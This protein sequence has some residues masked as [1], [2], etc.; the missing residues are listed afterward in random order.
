MSLKNVFLIFVFVFLVVAI[1]L[2][3]VS[4]LA[5]HTSYQSR[6]SFQA[7]Y[8][9]EGRLETY[10]PILGDKETCQARQDLLLQIS[11]I[12]CQPAVVRSD[13]VAEQN[14]PVFCQID[15]LQI[16]PL[17][18]IDKIRSISFSERYPKD[19]IGAGFHPAK[20]ALRS[21]DKLLGSPLINNIGYVVVVLKR[22]PIE[23][24]LPDFVN[25]SLTARIDYEAGNAF[26]VGSAQYLLEPMG[27]EEWE[28]NKFR[29]SFWE[30]RYF[31]RLEKADPNSAIVSLYSGKRKIATT[32]VNK[33]ETSRTVWVPGA[34]CRAGVKVAY[35]GFQTTRASAVLAISGKGT[36]LLDVYEGSRFLNDKC[37]VNRINIFENNGTGSVVMACSDNQRLELRLVENL[38]GVAK[39]YDKFYLAERYDKTKEIDIFLDSNKKERSGLVLFN[40]KI[41]VPYLEGKEVGLIDDNIMQLN[42][43]YFDGAIKSADASYVSD[44]IKNKSSFDLINGAKIKD[45]IIT[46]NIKTDSSDA[47][48][49]ELLDAINSLEKVADE[50]PA[51]RERDV[52]GSQR[53]G[54]LA[55][56]RAIELAGMAGAHEKKAELIR[57]FIEIYSDSEFSEG[58]RYELSRMSDLDFSKAVG[59][60]NIDNR[61]Y[62]I[63]LI[64]LKVPREHSN[65]DFVVSEIKTGTVNVRLENLTV[66]GD[67][68]VGSVDSIR[69]DRII[70]ENSVSATVNCRT[71]KAR[72]RGYNIKS[73]SHSFK[74]GDEAIKVCEKSYMRVRDIEIKEIVKVRLL[75]EAQGTRTET[76][77]TV[78]IGIEKRAIKLST[79]KTEELIENL[80]KSIKKWE[81]INEK[82]GNIVTGMKG[83]CFATAGVLT[84][85][86]F[87]TGISGEALARQK[88]MQGW[89]VECNSLVNSGKY[90]TLSACYYDKSNEI[91][92]DVKEAQKAVNDINS[93]IE[94]IEKNYPIESGGIF[95]GKDVDRAKAAVSYCNDLKSRYG[96]RKVKTSSGDKLLSEVL[97]DCDA[98]Y[99]KQGLYGYNE[100]RE[101]EYNLIMQN[102]TSSRNIKD[103][104]GKLLQSGYDQILKNRKGYE[105]FEKEKQAKDLGLP[106]STQLTGSQRKNIVSEVVDA[107]RVSSDV[108]I[109]GIT[110]VDTHLASINVYDSRDTSVSGIKRK[111]FVPGNYLLG[112]AKDSEGGYIVQDVYVKKSE[113][114]YEKLLEEREGEF[115]E[116]Y[117]IGRITSA[118]SV[119]YVN[120][121]KNPEV[122]YYESE[123]Y[124]GMP[125]IVPFDVREGWYA[126]TRQT[127]P[128]FGGIGAF[129]ASGR[130]TSFYLCNV[131]SNRQEQFFEGYGDD[132]CQLINLNTGQPLGF[133]PG[134]SESDARRKVG[135]AVQAIEEAARKY[136]KKIVSING[137]DF[138]VGNPAAN[139]PATQCQNFMS[140]EE[141][142]LLFNVCDPV[143]CPSSRCDFGGKYP[144]ADVV[145]TG[146]IGSSLLCLPNLREGIVVPVCLTGIHAGIEG[147]VSILRNHRDCLQESLATGRTVGICD[148]I[149]SVYLCEFFWRQIAPV[150]KVILPK[151]VESA[152]G[153]G[154]RGGG[155]YLTVM[156]AWQNM[157]NSIDYFTQSYAVNSIKA[158]R[159]RSIEE[160]GEPFCK[161]FVSAKAPTSFKTLIEP[162]SPPQFHAW[163]SSTK[164]TDVTLP[165]TSQYKVF[166][167]IFAGKDQGVHY[168][169]Y[170]RNPPES[171]YYSIPYNVQVASGFVGRG[172]YATESRDFTASEGYKELCVRVNDQEE[173]GFKEV[174]TSLAVNYLRDSYAS[175]ELG[176]SNIK[177]ESECVSG[178]PNLKAAVLSPNIQANAEEALLPQVYQRGI[179]RI[180]AS[181]NPGSKSDPLRF[182][183]VGYCGDQKIRCWLDK[184]SVKNAITDNN[185]KLENITLS[186]IEKRQRDDL[187][188]KGIIVGDDVAVAEIKELRNVVDSIRTAVVIDYSKVSESLVRLDAL[189]NKTVLNHHKA[190]ILYMIGDVKAIVV[191]KEI[192]LKNIGMNKESSVTTQGSGNA[193]RTPTSSKSESGKNL[194]LQSIKLEKDYE[195]NNKNYLYDKE[196]VTRLY[197]LSDKVYFNVPDATS[198]DLKVGEIVNSHIDLNY[199]EFIGAFEDHYE[200]TGVVLG[201]TYFDILNGGF[202]QE[203]K[204]YNKK[205]EKT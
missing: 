47:K 103:N 111:G 98:G 205:K 156:A 52:E 160:A 86:N 102:S 150:A 114:N 107:K 108:K 120:P 151:I 175:N 57:K 177:S 72:D 43:E 96:T 153:Q 125:A 71:E 115:S 159:A 42:K 54:E 35:D 179:V 197:I 186:E 146:I 68:G 118:E 149:Y 65:A 122:R 139:L 13:L 106:S 174:S 143:I 145:Q 93:R 25:V 82:L 19:V 113:N 112:L 63:R 133:F 64:D 163:F 34:Y 181:E 46:L 80:N 37:S 90:P 134:L 124:K 73:G 165:A 204:I 79:E 30:G 36:D 130:V 53:W 61:Y 189:F 7:I 195:F 78:R 99:N 26:G 199:N 3:N 136:G 157:Q 11:P 117:G 158:F 132:I 2:L 31:V 138:A 60:V 27:D 131:G 49:K 48:D 59:T 148:Q 170:L 77:L 152:Y 126:A 191:E 92:N 69:L 185:K 24:E 164:F 128:A 50:Y 88:I 45:D 33:G 190:Q 66:L 28:G 17:I 15:A 23:K 14:V 95:G 182:V 176:E 105:E 29:N 81:N 167:H 5:S 198:S 123:P 51:E 161:A 56:R 12:G 116:I 171:G 8:G 187:A 168:N 178:S 119:S 94:N 32:K 97:G 137:K 144:V 22:N 85:E 162:D 44:F 201:K 40:G 188:R 55:L 84:V 169:V 147:F 155:E 183:N 18:D 172:Q 41:F 91:N 39:R 76:N 127:L 193:G 196:R 203:D 62:N 70:D 202:I 1:S 74:I 38:A 192:G 58:Y 121:Y 166:Y 154:T 104:S 142:H 4:G 180:C 194:E 9:P 110:G 87:L 89:T 109:D 173:C 6:P 20:A 101:V 100:L 67:N 140:P 184:E 129:D 21:R 141:C 16:N 83:A 75:P 200:N 135:Q 10:W